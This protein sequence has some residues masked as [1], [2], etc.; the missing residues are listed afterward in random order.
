MLHQFTVKFDSPLGS[1][2][3]LLR[4]LAVRHVD[5]RSIGLTHIDGQTTAV[6]TT[7]DDVITHEVLVQRNATFTEGQVIFTFVPD[8]PGALAEV[9][10]RLLAADL[11][12]H[13]V[14]LL[15]WHQGK[16]EL[17]IS[18]DKPDLAQRILAAPLEMQRFSTE[19]LPA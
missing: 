5:L 11:T 14:V 10:D 12:V 4:A 9:A 8:Q 2:A 16:A 15:R 19:H 13:G 3:E 1:V 6:F 7:S 17:A 18:V